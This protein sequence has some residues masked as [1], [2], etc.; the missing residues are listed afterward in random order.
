MLG[1]AALAVG[2]C[3]RPAPPAADDA[4]RQDLEAAQAGAPRA[5]RTQFVSAL[6]LG[7]AAEAPARTAPRAAPARSAPSRPVARR[8]PSRDAAAPVVRVARAP[9]VEDAP[10]PAAEPAEQVADVPTID[11][12]VAPLPAPTRDEPIVAAPSR[13]P[14]E[15]PPASRRRGPVWTTG[16][17]IRNA[18][19]P[20]NP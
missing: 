3:S 9:R 1:A 15:G 7:R 17:V 4:L 14:A 12:E 11:V 20:I 2:A 19:F 6:E 5:S 18:P 13:R 16:D 10:A 8:T